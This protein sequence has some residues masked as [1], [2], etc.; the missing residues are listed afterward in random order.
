M[1]QPTK[2]TKASR[3]SGLP[4]VGF[5]GELPPTEH[6]VQIGDTN[7]YKT[8]TEPVEPTDCDRWPS[9]PFCGGN[10]WTA[11]PVGFEYEVA[12]NGCGICF[13]IIPVGGF[14][15]LPPLTYCYLDPACDKEPL[16]EDQPE[17]EEDLDWSPSPPDL[18]LPTI[19]PGDPEII[20]FLIITVVESYFPGH[21][22]SCGVEF[23]QPGPYKVGPWRIL[24][25]SKGLGNFTVKTFVSIPGVDHS[26]GF[27]LGDLNIDDDSY[28]YYVGGINKNIYYTGSICDRNGN[29]LATERSIGTG[30]SR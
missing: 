10:P 20:Y 11:L 28:Q 8:P 24:L 2:P 15:R 9:S 19:P 1:T 26:P 22:D 23:S 13:T 30:F 27:D 18:A 7:F 25:Y 16:A 4:E 5:S 6:L 3:N 14:T 21:F 12:H 17:E 29:L